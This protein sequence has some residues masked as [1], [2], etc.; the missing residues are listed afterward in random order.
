MKKILKSRKPGREIKTYEEFVELNPKM[1]FVKK[2]KYH[3]NEYGY[4]LIDVDHNYKDLLFDKLCGFEIYEVVDEYYSEEVLKIAEVLQ[5]LR[6]DYDE[7]LDLLENAE[8]LLNKGYRI[9]VNQNGIFY[10]NN[11]RRS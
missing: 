8:R 4:Q 10:R 3:W 11:K 6:D 5:H 2:R 9:E 7:D 1:V